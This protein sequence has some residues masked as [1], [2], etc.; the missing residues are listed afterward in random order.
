[1]IHE[2][3]LSLLGFEGDILGTS[4]PFDLFLCER[5]CVGADFKVKETVI[6][7][8]LISAAEV[9]SWFMA[10]GAIG[11]VNAFFFIHRQSM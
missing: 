2:V 5:S 6:E 11:E 9:R 10:Y 4:L 8:Q 7:N 3:L 1:M